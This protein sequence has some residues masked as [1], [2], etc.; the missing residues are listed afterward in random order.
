MRFV[1]RGGGAKAETMDLEL[2]TEKRIEVLVC[3]ASK[4]LGEKLRRALR[5]WACAACVELSLEVAALPLE[6]GRRAPLLFLDMD[7]V[8][9]SACDALNIRGTG[10]IVVSGDAGRVIHSYRWHPAAFLKPDFDARR[11]AEALNTCSRTWQSGRVCL[12]SPSP[13]KPFRLPLGRVR[14]VEAYRHYC[15]LAQ[16]NHAVKARFALGEL[17]EALPDPPFARCHKSYLVHLDAVEKISYTTLTLRDDGFTV[18]I[19]RTY[20]DDLCR[21]LDAWREGEPNYGGFHTGL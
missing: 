9:V 14:Y 16:K 7:S 18:P 13:R 21:A 17:E 20:H 19:G 2:T 5:R 11:L 4:A 8:D 1:R 12:N 6:Q 10:L 15:L 3:T